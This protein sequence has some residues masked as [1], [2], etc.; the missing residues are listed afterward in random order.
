MALPLY[1]AMT[2]PE[3]TACSS[4]PPHPAWMACHFSP[5][6]TGLSDLPPELGPEAMVIL[7]DRIPP[8]GHNPGHILA[9]L[10]R[11]R[12]GCILLD[13]QRSEDP[14]TA[15][16]VRAVLETSHHPVGV[17]HQYGK[18]LDCPVFLPPIPLDVSLEFYLAPWQEREIWMEAA[19]DSLRYT[20]TAQG[21][22]AG[23][24]PQVPE[25]GKLDPDLHCHYRVEVL[26]SRAEFSLWRTREDLN[27]LLEAAET[28]GVTKAIG[29]WQELG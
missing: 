14:E 17:S 4:L 1:L 29:L 13:F 11:L 19:A 22:V 6:G 16:I 23:P 5:Y 8:R 18:D 21:S 12:C 2:A 3:F 7:N 9:Q 15:A 10:E 28:L 26:E 27:A 25:Q 20:V 24:L